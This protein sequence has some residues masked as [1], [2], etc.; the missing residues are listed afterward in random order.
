MEAGKHVVMA[1]S[2]INDIDQSSNSINTTYNYL[3]TNAN[4]MQIFRKK[5]K[6]VLMED[7]HIGKFILIILGPEESDE[8]PTVSGDSDLTYYST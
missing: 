1:P 3:C 6:I 7:I 8:R 2:L 5:A 4:A